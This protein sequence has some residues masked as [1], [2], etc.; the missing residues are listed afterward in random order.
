MTNSI[1]FKMDDPSTR[2]GLVMIMQKV[3]KKR[4]RRFW[5][6][7]IVANRLLRGQFHILFEE[8]KDD[9]AKFLNY[10]RMPQAAFDELVTTI[11]PSIVRQNTVMR[12]P[13]PP[14]ES[15]AICLR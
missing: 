13:I 6:H 11:T 4:K 5:V 1:I 8:L 7:P 14:V 15:V 9:D 12:A 3:L 2:L 10:F